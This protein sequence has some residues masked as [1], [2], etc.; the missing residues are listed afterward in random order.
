MKHS[1]S[2]Q[3]ISYIA[4]GAPARRRPASG[5]EPPFRYELGFTP[6]WYRAS[7]GINFGERWHTDPEYR[8]E[9]ILSM[10]G[11]LKRRFPGTTIGGIDRP[12]KPLDV[13]TGTFG[14]SLIAG[15][16]GIPIVYA[17]NNW[18][19]NAHQFLTP[20]EIDNLEPPDLEKNHLFQN[21]MEQVEWIASKEGYVEGY[22]NWQGVLNNAQRI[23]GQELFYDMF[24]APER[25]NHLF[26]C[27]CSTIIDAAGRLHERQLKSGVE[28][29]FFTIS[30]CLVNMV[31]PDIYR[32]LLLP[33]DKKIQE[34]FGQLSVH[35]CSWNANPYVEYYAS[36]PNLGYIDMGIESDLTRARN[37]FPDARRAL[38]YT[39]MD[40]V[41]KSL[42][43][44]R[45]DLEKIAG[46]FAPCDIIVADIDLGTPDERVIDFIKLCEDIGTKLRQQ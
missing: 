31:S 2:C 26:E 30:N 37:L 3:Q 34:A 45:K 36:I 42:E 10:R 6:N 35:N 46:D 15:I 38:M 4:P 8:R 12:D 29:N 41:N 21:L 9:T 28:I 7:L 19:T 43:Q 32:E 14:S 23:R 39:P 1:E 33:F 20:D 5:N 24:A 11:E 40:L 44:I 17:E 13:L 25:C 27:I 18:P 16:Y 22:I